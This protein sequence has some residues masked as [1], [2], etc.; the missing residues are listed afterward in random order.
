MPALSNPFRLAQHDESMGF[1]AVIYHPGV[2]VPDSGIRPR[3]LANMVVYIPNLMERA[4]WSSSQSLNVFLYDK[5]NSIKE[6]GELQYLS[7]LEILVN[8]DDQTI[9]D[10]A[11]ISDTAYEDLKGSYKLVFEKDLVIANKVWLLV[12]TP[13]PG[14]F[15]RR[16]CMIPAQ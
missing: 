9:D 14:T 5:T 15:E 2:E 4:A 12:A 10:L 6:G 11:L 1:S 8:E 16:A 13:V 7:G 3:D